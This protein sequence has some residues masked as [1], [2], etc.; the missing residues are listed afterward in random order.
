MSRPLPLPPRGRPV[1][2]LAPMQDVTD[3]PFW[4]VIHRYGGPDLYYTEY[5]RTHRD[6]K[7]ERHIV[8]AVRENPTGRPV[9][10]Q[11]IG[12]DIAALVRT[13]GALQRLP[14]AGIDLN[15]G[16]PAP[17]V[18]RK[19]AGGAL[20]RD[21][22]RVDAILAALRQEVGTALTVKSRVGFD[23]PGEFPGILDV[24][25]GHGIDALTVHGRTV[26]E[27]YGPVVH[28]DRIAEACARAA[29]PV[30]ANGSV[31][32]AVSAK[33]MVAETGARGLMIG[34]AAV[35]N[36]WVFAQIR[37]AFEGRAGPRPAPRDIREYIGE[38]YR[39]TSPEG[40]AEGLR[41][42]K[43]K[44]YLNFILPGVGGN[45]E[46]L[47]AVRRAATERELF[48]LCDGAL[49]SDAPAAGWS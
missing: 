21:L 48:R 17:I 9:I 13:A 16:C 34:R 26:R 44:K 39:E 3:L 43:L 10:A 1:L 11:M 32:D 47:R 37:A 24:V 18:C 20:L 25:L 5:F 2:V 4:R 27:G 49:D 14:V 15:L 22:G 36:P 19:N 33:S 35:R 7:P 30:F 31:V 6:S 41:V 38:L 12:Q 46:L 29:C 42:S 23:S 28:R 45:D 8:R 40:L